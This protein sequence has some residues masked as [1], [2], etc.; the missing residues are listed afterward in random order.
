MATSYAPLHLRSNFT[1]FKGAA[2]AEAM[3]ARAATWGLPAA[4]IADENNLCGAVRFFQ[5][6]RELDLHAILGAT[7][8]AGEDE[9]VVLAERAEGYANLCRLVSLC[10]LEEKTDLVAK[11]AEHQEG[12]IALVSD[13]KLLT[14][15]AQALPPDRLCAEVVRPADSY[16]NERR[17][18]ESARRLGCPPNRL[19]GP[20]LRS[21]AGCRSLAHT[22]RHGR[23]ERARFLR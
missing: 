2:S 7:L 16:S 6:A 21:S 13:A 18:I 1:F 17:L 4:A 14:R 3:L 8:R 9:L 20:S 19:H 5:A 22:R 10:N 23:Q 12:L 15:L 11:L